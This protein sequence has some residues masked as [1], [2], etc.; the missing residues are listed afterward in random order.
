MPNNVDNKL[1]VTGTKS[2]LIEFK[3]FARGREEDQ[4]ISVEPFIPY[5]SDEIRLAN[6]ND[7]E[8]WRVKHWGI[9]W[10]FYD[11]DL[12]IRD[13]SLIY[14]FR[15]PWS[16]PIH[17]VYIMSLKFDSMIFTLNFWELAQGGAVGSFSI[18]RG[19]AFK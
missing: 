9:K 4:A 6:Q 7:I 2:Q 14:R 19:V 1:V 3:E 18:Q 12:E 13:D 10:D 17:I 16:P 5:P 11:T 15:T 8:Q